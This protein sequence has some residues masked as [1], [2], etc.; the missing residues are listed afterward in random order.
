MT[1]DLIYYLLAVIV[2]SFIVNFIINKYYKIS[3]TKLFIFTLIS[4]F[5]GVLTTCIMSY[6]ESGSFKGTSFYGAIFLMPIYVFIFSKIFKIEFYKL[7][8]L[9]SF[10]GMITS[11]ILKVRC[12]HYGCCG[13]RKITS[14]IS[15]DF[16]TFPSQFVELILAFCILN[17][18]LFFF[19]RNKD[20]KDLYPIMMFI[21]GIGRF[22]LNSFRRVQPVLGFMAYG[23]LWS[24]V[25]II[26]GLI[27]ILRIM[28]KE[29][30]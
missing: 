28:K 3:N 11:M 8:N 24:I 26:I 9:T 14:F 15:K 25:S 12:L 27:F 21:Y 22:I 7:I 19:Y 2:L 4:P 10:L 30:F 20:R 23:H 18:L 13:G 29:I 1:S 17:I 6:V 16:V 5:I